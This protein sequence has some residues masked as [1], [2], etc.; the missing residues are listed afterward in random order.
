MLTTTS[1]A[2]K[3][4]LDFDPLQADIA[5]IQKGYASGTWSIHEI[6]AIYLQRIEQMNRKGP[7]L[8]AII[9]VNPH[10]LTIA[11]SLDALYRAG[12]IL[13]PLHGIPI[14]LKDNIE[15]R[16]SMPTT[17]GS[18]ALAM[19]Y[20]PVDAQLTA[21]LRAAGAIILAK[22]NLSEWANFRGV[23]SISGWSALGGFTRNPYILT[24]NPCGSSS[25]SAVAVA[26]GFAPIAI[27]TETNG[28]I[29]C[30]SQSNGLVGLKPTVGLVSAKGIIPIAHSQDAAGPIAKT[31][32]DAAL[33]LSIIADPDTANPGRFTSWDPDLTTAERL[34]F[35]NLNPDSLDLS[36]LRIGIYS[37]ALGEDQR[38]DALFH[39]AKAL[40]QKKGVEF[41]EVPDILAPETN[42]A[43]FE[44]MLYE[45]HLGLNAYL[46][47]LDS[48][49]PVHNLEELIAFNNTD[50]VE[51]QW[52]G[53]EYLEM[54]LE[55]DSSQYDN[56]LRNLDKM[57]ANS[58]ALGID[59][60]MDSLKLDAIMAPSG[61]PAWIIDPVNGDHYI[62]GSSSPAAISG[63]P[64]LSLP[65]GMIKGLPV[66]L[67]L[68]GRQGSELL[69]LQIAAIYEAERKAIKAPEFLPSDPLPK[70]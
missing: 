68:F 7:N 21:R 31:I 23:R 28:S 57:Q 61:A 53:Q 11:D 12:Q 52:F 62:L 66:G 26:A 9:S 55:K 43:S 8:G 35:Q 34:E 2:Q 22:A 56:Y 60:I 69:L 13:G 19:N 36:T 18:R 29:I 3:D 54:A 41:V 33:V 59:R 67:S 51:L 58:R 15:S 24:R 46:S 45:F 25:G 17:A 50:S 4:S 16:D 6:T 38:V 10:A 37:Q 65:M 42:Y 70:N 5:A 27:G 39:Q 48:T 47:S 63:Y 30:P 64:N 44:V 32:R 1:R 14:I 20:R 40:L 49:L